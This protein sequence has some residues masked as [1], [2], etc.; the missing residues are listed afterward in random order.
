MT[1]KSNKSRS[2]R[3]QAA[4]MRSAYTNPYKTVS[5][6]Q[7]RIQQEVQQER[8]EG[9]EWRERRNAER[10]QKNAGEMRQSVVEAAL[11]NP[12]I[13]V[14]EAQLREQYQHVMRD[15]RSMFVLAGALVVVLVALS[16]VLP[17]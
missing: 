11:R 3:E 16:V 8:A 14:T 6:A 15:V 2:S 12:T 5:S 17:K 13:V 4:K 10:R 1:N 9:G 7:R